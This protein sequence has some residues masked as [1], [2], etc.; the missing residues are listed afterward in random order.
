LLKNKRQEKLVTH[1]KQTRI[2]ALQHWKR[3]FQEALD[4][5]IKKENLV[6]AMNLLN[7]IDSEILTSNALSRAE[8][9]TILE[10]SD[11]RVNDYNER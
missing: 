11:G 7:Q 9:N 10:E 2:Q 3:V 4:G 1:L 5:S 6:I 8:K